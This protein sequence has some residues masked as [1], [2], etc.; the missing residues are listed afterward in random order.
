M[1]GL[2]AFLGVPFD[3]AMVTPYEGPRMT[4]GLHDVSWGIG[5]PNFLKRHRIEPD[6]GVAWRDPKRW[7]DLAPDAARLAETL[8]YE[9]P[10]QRRGATGATAFE[11]F[12]EGTL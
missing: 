12:E 8:A 5:D 6:L 7:V 11:G 3:D 1:A 10:G 2:A 4:D 9:L